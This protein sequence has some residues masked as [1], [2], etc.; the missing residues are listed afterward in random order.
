MAIELANLA[1]AFFI[2][3]Q[4]SSHVSTAQFYAVFFVA[5]MR[6]ATAPYLQRFVTGETA[7]A[8]VILGPILTDVPYEEA[9]MRNNDGFEH[10]TSNHHTQT[11]H[12]HITMPMLQ[13]SK[14]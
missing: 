1:D 7:I 13:N 14:G 10:L 9:R 11:N 2:L 5:F 3:E 12:E 6:A 8:G 4:L